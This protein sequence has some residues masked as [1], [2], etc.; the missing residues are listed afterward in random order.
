MVTTESAARYSGWFR[1]G[2]RSSHLLMCAVSMIR[3]DPALPRSL[4]GLLRPSAYPHPVL[5]VELIETQ[6]S[7]ILIAGERVYKLK[8]PV[9]YSFVDQK[10]LEDRRRLCHEELRLNRRFASQLYLG[11]CAITADDGE[12]RIGGDGRPIEYA[13]VMQVFDRHEQLDQLV[14]NKRLREGEIERF[15][16]WLARAHQ[17]LPRG[18]SALG[19]GQPAAVAAATARNAGECVAASGI[20]GTGPRGSRVAELLA[21][22]AGYRQTALSWRA[23]A[24]FIRECHADLHLSNVVRLDGV[25]L[26]FDCLE[27]DPALRWIDT[28][29]DVAFL[30]ADLLGYDEPQMATRFLNSYLAESGDYHASVVLPLYVADRALVRAKVLALQA[31]N[32]H[33]QTAASAGLLRLRHERY[34]EIAE[35]SLQPRMPR[36][37][38]MMG[39]PGS[40]KSWLA[41]HLA[42][43]LTAAVIRSDL[44]RKRL[45]GLDALAQSHSSAGGGLYG[46]RQTDLV[47]ERLARCAA[48]VLGGRRDVIVD[49]NFGKRR[50]RRVLAELCQL[51][52]VPLTVVQCEAPMPVLRERIASRLTSAQDPSEADLA[53][54]ELQAAEREDIVSDERLQVIVADTTV[55][56]AVARVLEQLP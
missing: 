40:G 20:F 7:W 51:M 31:G 47:Y 48:E 56:N 52:A 28:A 44:E 23:E 45:A 24:G 35:H 37:L 27:F 39:L 10:H 46:E 4:K 34:L 22:E 6:L 12:A 21:I 11:V 17:Q 8:R 26:P 54:L 32:A 25:L 13:V 2:G 55:K 33:G 53:I 9:S 3:A 36:C 41:A 5:K 49:A 14:L 15:G 30:Y 50:H 1:R 16:S 29:Q 18:L 42:A 43:E 38:M 19:V